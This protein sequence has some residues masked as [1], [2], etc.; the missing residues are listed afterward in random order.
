MHWS[1]ASRLSRPI[2]RMTDRDGRIWPPAKPPSTA[3]TAG[4]G[5]PP[6]M[7]PRVSLPTGALP[8]YR[9][10]EGAEQEVHGE[11]GHA[12]AGERCEEGGARRDRPYAPGHE[13]PEEFDHAAADARDQA[14][15][16]GDEGRVGGPVGDRDLLRGRHDQVDVRD[17]RRRVQPERNGAYVGAVLLPREPVGLPGVEDVAHE[18][19]DGDTRQHMAVYQLR[20]EAEHADQHR[21]YQQE[22]YHVVQRY[23]AEAVDVAP[24]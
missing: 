2:G 13:S 16:P 8:I 17:H 24:A 3:A 12:G 23:G 15:A 5:R 6:P 19:G 10:G 20:P 18:V 9:M 4:T 14:D 22:L 7:S 11:E 1:E 21:R